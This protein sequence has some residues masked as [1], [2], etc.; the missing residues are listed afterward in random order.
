MIKISGI[1]VWLIIF[2]VLFGLFIAQTINIIKN[3]EFR[4]YMTISDFKYSE[5]EIANIFN[6]RVEFDFSGR[7][8]FFY[9]NKLL[10]GKAEYFRGKR[11][12]TFYIYNLVG[13]PLVIG[14]FKEGELDGELKCFD[15]DGIIKNKFH[16]KK[17][18]KIARA[19]DYRNGILYREYDLKGEELHGESIDYYS[20]GNIKSVENY[21]DDMLHGTLKSYY[22]NG[23]L[24]DDL[25]YSNDE[26]TGNFRKYYAN[27]NLM[28]EGTAIDGYITEILRKYNSSG[29][30]KEDIDCDNIE[31]KKIYDLTDI[32]IG[33]NEI[34]K[35]EME[36]EVVESRKDSNKKRNFESKNKS[37]NIT[38]IIYFYDNGEKKVE[39]QL[40]NNDLRGQIKFFDKD[41]QNIINAD[42][43]KTGE[44]MTVEIYDEKRKLLKVLYFSSKQIKNLKKLYRYDKNPIYNIS[45]IFPHLENKIVYKMLDC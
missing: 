9:K 21:R 8:E 29:E 22:M 33:N 24:N 4:S 5:G 2:I 39:F 35:K 11:H 23:Q 3:M 10:K 45:F 36:K 28:L 42:I 17:G 15:N 25:Y 16:Y 30:I 26:L 19:Y 32:K 27:G 6:E 41:E 20:N 1:V 31:K 38:E 40:E 14:T 37:R 43:H 44:N 34:L 13:I 12:G 7:K 18:E